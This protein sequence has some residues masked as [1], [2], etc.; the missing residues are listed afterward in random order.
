[1]P[2]SGV[3][4]SA[5]NEGFAIAEASFTKNGQRPVYRFKDGEKLGSLSIGSIAS[6]YKESVDDEDNV[7]PITPEKTYDLKNYQTGK[8]IIN[9]PSVSIT[10]DEASVIK[11]GIVFRGKYAEIHGAGF[12]D[13]TITIQPKKAGAIIDFKGT[14]L[15]K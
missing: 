14:R 7:E 5:N 10:L 12:A 8:L 11:N 3:D 9:K 1:M 6:D 2:A 4:I 15:E 13:E